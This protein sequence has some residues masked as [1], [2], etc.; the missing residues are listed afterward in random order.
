MAKLSVPS[1]ITSTSPASAAMLWCV[2]SA[3]TGSISISELMRRSLLAAAMALGRPSAT[4]CSSY[5]HLPL[6]VVEFDKVAI[7]DP[8]ES[9]AGANECFRDDRT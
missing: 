8:H 1:T 2:T 5:K 7:H 3:T 4:S 9:N 6:Q